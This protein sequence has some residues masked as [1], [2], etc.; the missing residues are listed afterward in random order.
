MEP[1]L[2]KPLSE[3]ELEA[4]VQSVIIQLDASGPQDMGKV[5]GVASKQLVGKAD[6]RGISKMVRRL[7]S[8][9]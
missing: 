6:G 2:P 7:L 3:T 5:M 8:N 1:Y 4:A 9:P